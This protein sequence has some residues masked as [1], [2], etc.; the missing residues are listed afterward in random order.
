MNL[1]YKKLSASILILG[2]LSWAQYFI[3]I[4]LNGSRG[5]IPLYMIIYAE[6]FLIFF[7][8][9]YLVKK[10]ADVKDDQQEKDGIVRRLC[11]MFSL[12][13]F[14]PSSYKLPLIIILFGMIFRLTLLPAVPTTSQDV[15][16]YIWEGKEISRGFN[17]YK[18]APDSPE[19]A[20]INNHHLLDKVT[21]KNLTSIYPPFAQAAFTL[22]Y[23]ISGENTLGLKLIYLLC[24]LFTM[25]FIIKLLSLEKKNLNLVILYAWLPLPIMEFFV[26]AHI[27]PLGITF[28]VMFLYY[29]KKK[30]Y[31]ISSAALALSFLAK[32]YPVV[33]IPLLLK[34]IKLKKTI[35][36]S[37]VFG[38]VV[39]IF[40]I[41]FV[42]GGV[43][44]FGMLSNYIANWEFNGSVYHLMKWVLVYGNHAHM[45]CNILL[46]I[47]ILIISF[48]YKNF[49]TAAGAVLLS[50]IIFTATVYP[51]YLGWVASINP[52]LE[53]YSLLSLFFTINLTNLTPLAPVWKEFTWVILTE[54]VVFFILLGYDL[55]RL[56]KKSTSYKV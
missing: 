16:R 21:F 54:Y 26:N 39:I 40:Y 56:K 50:V 30:K 37:A 43:R 52:F 33:L 11:K 23:L 55:F 47:S 2:I 51:W 45:V 28:L 17:P 38:A 9:Y 34:K 27:D 53:F 6:A 22:G 18:Y 5:S 31:T 24:E 7:A 36:F 8:A 14:E 44:V 15:Y 4:F 19:L 10:F 49:I 13:D 46:V 29:F 35:Y 1:R 41:P 32:L 20:V 48:S 25:I 12:K 3:F 42:R